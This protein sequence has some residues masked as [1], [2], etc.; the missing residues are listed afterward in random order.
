MSDG[1]GWVDGQLVA[2]SYVAAREPTVHVDW[3]HGH[4]PAILKGIAQTY[5]AEGK[6]D[7]A[8]EGRRK[9]S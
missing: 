6:A 3:E 9:V 4:V 8:V 7:K 5:G 1:A 2:P